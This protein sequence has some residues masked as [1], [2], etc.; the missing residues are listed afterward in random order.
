MI[1][2]RFKMGRTSGCRDDFAELD[3][4]F[5]FARE[6]HRLGFVVTVEQPKKA[7]ADAE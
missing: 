2:V 7:K 1:A 5:A 4:A 6:V 3:E